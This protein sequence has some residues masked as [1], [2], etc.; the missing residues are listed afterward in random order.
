MSNLEEDRKTIALALLRLAMI[1]AIKEEDPLDENFNI[2]NIVEELM[3]EAKNSGTIK[4][5]EEITGFNE[6]YVQ[7][8]MSGICQEEYRKMIDQ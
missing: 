7:T 1:Q 6:E 8:L 2:S 5:L 4:A 3:A